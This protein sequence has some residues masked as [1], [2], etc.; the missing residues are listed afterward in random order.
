[1]SEGKIKEA[2]NICWE[3]CDF[4][5][6]LDDNFD[7]TGIFDRE[8]D[9][10]RRA[11]HERLMDILNLTGRHQTL[12]ITDRLDEIDYNGDTLFKKINE[13]KESSQCQQIK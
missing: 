6:S 8:K 11:I 2:K 9:K 5:K 4:V 3:Y 7:L 12:G 1:M 10:K 13:Q